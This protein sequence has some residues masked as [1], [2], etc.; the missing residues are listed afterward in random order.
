M[1]KTR[2]LANYNRAR[3][4]KKWKKI[5]ESTSHHIDIHLGMRVTFRCVVFAKGLYTFFTTTVVTEPGIST[6]IHTHTHRHTFCI[7]YFHHS[8]A[9]VFFIACATKCKERSTPNACC[10]NSRHWKQKI[11]KQAFI[12]RKFLRLSENKNWSSSRA[13]EMRKQKAFANRFNLDC[14]VARWMNSLK[15]WWLRH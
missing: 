5:T 11:R 6:H 3:V 9:I 13:D 15:I 14:S 12:S 7:V 2:D 8:T 10:H 4:K 1:R